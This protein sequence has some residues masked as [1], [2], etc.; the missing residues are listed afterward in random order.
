MSESTKTVSVMNCWAALYW[1]ANPEL[2]NAIGSWKYHQGGYDDEQDKTRCVWGQACHFAGVKPGSPRDEDKAAIPST[3]WFEFC[4]K[5]SATNRSLANAAQEL[6]KLGPAPVIFFHKCPAIS[7]RGWAAID[8]QRAHG[9][10][11]TGIVEEP[12]VLLLRTRSEQEGRDANSP[13]PV[14]VESDPESRFRL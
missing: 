9:V 14:I 11:E 8:W 2:Q 10:P 1:A 3:E 7:L 5:S 12:T 13:H 6:R 4:A